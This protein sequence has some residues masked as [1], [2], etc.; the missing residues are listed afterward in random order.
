MNSKRIANQFHVHFIS[1]IAYSSKQ[2]AVQWLS[3][4]F[5]SKSEAILFIF[6]FKRTE[7]FVHESGHR[8]SRCV[9]C[10]IRGT[11]LCTLKM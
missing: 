9:R 1:D 7:S 3:K 5:T 8:S 11:L 4:Q 10:C 6:S 2:I